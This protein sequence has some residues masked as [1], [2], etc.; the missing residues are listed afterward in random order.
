ML[1]QPLSSFAETNMEAKGFA[2]TV[3]HWAGDTI[4]KYRQKGMANGYPDGT[5]KPDRGMKRS[6]MA[7]FV[8]RFFGFS[9]E[10]EENFSD[11]N[12]DDW[13]ASDAAKA[14][15]YEYIED[16]EM[17]PEESASRLDVV[18]ALSLI[19]D[20]SEQSKK[21][22]TIRFSDMD[23]L[24]LRDRENIESFTKRGYI[25]GYED[26]TF[27]PG[28]NVSRAEILSIM[29][30]VLG[31]I[32]MT[33]ED[34]DAIPDGTGKITV[35]GQNII[36]ENM[37][38]E[39]SIYITA[40]VKKRVTFKDIVI[41]GTLEIAG[42]DVSL[43]GT[44]VNRIVVAKAKETPLLSISGGRA[45]TIETKSETKIVM[46][47]DAKAGIIESN[48]ETGIDIDEGSEVGRL[49]ANS[50]TTVSGSGKIE[51]TYL[52]SGELEMEKKTGYIRV[53]G[54]GKAM[55]AGRK[56]TRSNDD[57][58]PSSGAGEAVAEK[59]YGEGT[60]QDPFRI[61]KIED[62]A[63]VG[64]GNADPSG[65]PWDM[66][67][68][69]ILE[70]DLDFDSG[71]SYES[72]VADVSYTARGGGEGWNPIGSFDFIYEVMN[73]FTGSFDGKGKTI[74]HMYINRS[75]TVVQG[76]FGY[77]YDA[78]IRDVRLLEIDARLD[79]YS[80]GLVGFAQDSRIY[81][82]SVTGRVSGNEYI[83]AL[84]GIV[85]SSD[86]KFNF[87]DAYVEGTRGIGGFAGEVIGSQVVDNYATGEV[88]GQEV[89]GGFAGVFTN[90]L[91]KRNYAAGS[92][93][94]GYNSI[95]GF[96]GQADYSLVSDCIAFG[97]SLTGT[98]GMGRIT[99]FGF[100][101]ILDGNYANENMLVN[102]IAVSSIDSTTLSG[103]NL[104]SM[105][106]TTLPP[107]S[108]WDFKNIWEIKDG[109]VRPTFRGEIGG[110]DSQP[111][112]QD[113]A[114]STG[115]DAG[116]ILLTAGMDEIGSVY[117][118][119]LPSGTE[120]PSIDEIIGGTGFD[121]SGNAPCFDLHVIDGLPQSANYDI[122]IAAV[123]ASGDQSGIACIAGVRA[124]RLDYG[125][126][127][128][129][130]PYRV[131]K[132]ED[133]ARMGTGKTDP[134]GNIWRSWDSYMLMNDLDFTSASSYDSGEVDADFIQGTTT[135]GWNPI[136]NMV[137]SF[138]GSFDGGG[139]AIRNLMIS[140][141]DSLY[142]GMFGVI[143]GAEIKDISLENASVIGNA[144]SGVLVG[145]AFDDSSISG[146][147]SS[148]TISGAGQVGGLA[149]TLD[150][151]TI[152][153]SWSSASVHAS[154]AY[155]GGLVGYATNMCGS[156]KSAISDSYAMGDVA[157][158]SFA[159]GLAGNV[160]SGS[161]I[162][163]CYAA[164]DVSV[165]S[166]HAGGL[167]GAIYSSS[168]SGCAAMGETVG[169]GSDA[170][171][172]TGYISGGTISG[173]FANS[174][175]LVNGHVVSSENAE[176]ISGADMGNLT[177]KEELP[178]FAWDFDSVW[179]MENGA[180]RPTLR[181][182][183]SDDTVAP[184]FTTFSALAGEEG[185]SLSASM[186]E[187]GTIFYAVVA[188]GSAALT[189]EQIKYGSGYAAKGYAASFDNFSLSGLTVGDSYDIYMVAK[190]SSG[191]SSAVS[192]VVGIKPKTIVYGT[193]TDSDPFQ[194]RTID[195]L[196]SIGSK[197][198]W[199][200]AKSFIL[201][202]DLDFASAGSYENGSGYLS[203][204]TFTIGSGW[205]PIGTET[206]RFSGNFDGNGHSIS[207]LFID[208]DSTNYQGMFGYADGAELADIELLSMEIESNLD[209]VGGLVGH[210]ASTTINDCSVSGTVEGDWTI[211]GMVGCAEN[212]TMSACSVDGYVVG[213]NLV[214][215][216]VGWAIGSSISGSNV[217]PDVL[218]S[219]RV[220]GLV[221]T[222]RGG[223]ISNSSATG[224]VTGEE[225]TGGFVGIL[226]DTTGDTSAYT[227]EVSSCAA[228]GNVSGTEKVGGFAGLIGDH[229]LAAYGKT[230]KVEDCS[231]T[232]NV[233]GTIDVGGFVGSVYGETAEIEGSFALGAVTG[234]S[235]VGGFGGFVSTAIITGCHAIGSVS[236]SLID[237]N[238]QK[239]GGFIG[240]ADSNN[241]YCCY[242]SG[243]VA[244]YWA[245]GGFAGY[246]DN[247]LGSSL[248]HASY[249]LGEV[250][251]KKRVGGFAGTIIKADTNNYNS[252]Q[253]D[254][255]YSVGSVSG[256]DYAGGGFVGEMY[257][258]QITDSYASGNFVQG[259][260]CAG[261]FAGRLSGNYIERYGAI[262]I[263]GC[264]V[265]IGSVFQG[266][267]CG[268]ISPYQSGAVTLLGNYAN[269]SM[270]VDGSIIAS[271]DASSLSGADLADMI[272]EDF[273]P[274][275]GW[276]FDQADADG[277][278]A[279]WKIE[280]DMER[281]VLYA[282][283]DEYGTFEKLGTD[284]GMI[285]R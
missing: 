17:R 211:G 8:N 188:N 42:G 80:G 36:F 75:G 214:G 11:V 282:D 196:A 109:D 129:A 185:I 134:D 195:N 55:V 148:G 269:E 242:S 232:G 46:K 256:T 144:S 264:I 82:C 130:D 192:T 237:N 241:I 258:G 236:D 47:D 69:Y 21:E 120:A 132:I 54:V 168:I 226:G 274:F 70:A 119:V 12:S 225:Y 90:S 244:G 125:A 30:R 86:I 197:D 253:I 26:G 83:G 218:G 64:S 62:L 171:R 278:H 147:S 145:Y 34:A 202:N 37:E 193:G 81:E 143:D 123:D 13:F 74:S 267:D 93:Y 176:S 166:S 126:G 16:I 9:E 223:S 162:S 217:S 122:Y 106:A 251:G 77:A 210:A 240:F 40:G 10:A 136:G 31:Y 25:K 1:I 272:S 194:I 266:G 63:R 179:Q 235:R 3:N 59:D 222:L 159:G 262:R 271:E 209:Y 27:R 154:G 100:N 238:T 243:A 156:I 39:G 108:R 227:V 284:D 139:H 221:G 158:P 76:L 107:L 89:S 276:D 49:E 191:N 29:E 177:S 283:P 212:S 97:S 152:S 5:F 157:A 127:I 204:N 198:G 277:N 167:A 85:M 135:G 181:G 150:C 92:V 165:S 138:S 28:G 275:T 142:Q 50:N 279:Y 180:S 72:G 121:A 224:S 44:N 6:E 231:A 84:A 24:L 18:D 149:G 137:S 170:G 200:L 250:T 182:V 102:G 52:H 22:E 163:D 199:S 128:A 23:G 43:V 265:F 229:T 219:G 169:D 239:H 78:D 230:F 263:D 248:V 110:D 285:V 215:G 270:L 118:A 220:G 41:K 254:K 245:V 175:L 20:L 131:Y 173:N 88:H 155:A 207:N 19:L 183:G 32:V 38:I 117:Y 115:N 91:V 4:E 7:T 255:C 33:Q 187:T 174:G 87:T 201:M 252:M 60:T 95:G 153:R 247:S 105:L 101:F 281:P 103:A 206:N 98:S 124:G 111:L 79:V 257:F 246:I 65:N 53:Y 190:D 48:G 73:P 164:G 14:K 234:K 133:L 261:G 216:L 160:D 146:C 57:Y 141:T 2:D 273:L 51:R 71:E 112:L 189:K 172:V 58:K 68:H 161:G 213:D 249:S 15:Y 96:A 184:S 268:R 113:L 66:D 151:S 260:D 280:T 104:D 178:L 186:N 205:V 35:T 228:S 116:E 203:G 208:R 140:R 61:Y 67:D 114:A 45:E 56:I 233:S 259:V 94:G 99:G